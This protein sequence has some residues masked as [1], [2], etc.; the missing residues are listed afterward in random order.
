MYSVPLL[1]PADVLEAAVGLESDLVP[2]VGVSASFLL[3]SVLTWLDLFCF[4]LMAAVLLVSCEF[5]T[6]MCCS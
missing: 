1:I 2:R 4:L 3:S 5:P 6:E